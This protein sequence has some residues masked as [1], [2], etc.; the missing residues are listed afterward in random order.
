MTKLITSVIIIAITAGVIAYDVWVV[1]EPTPGDTISEVL[2]SWG[3]R[4][5]F[6]PWLWG[7][8]AGHLFWPMTKLGD[9]VLPLPFAAVSAPVHTYRWVA[10]GL[11]ILVTSALVA[12]T[13]GGM[14][15]GLHPAIPLTVGIPAGHWGWPQYREHRRPGG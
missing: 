11:L 6:L 3:E 2:L 8:L 5:L 4:H 7:G 10:L 15:Q 13:I 14:L 12:L 1:I 9:R